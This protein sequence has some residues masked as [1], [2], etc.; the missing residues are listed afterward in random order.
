MFL[1]WFLSNIG[2]IGV[3]LV[4]EMVGLSESRKSEYK[5]K[6]LILLVWRVN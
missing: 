5:V 2:Y 3:G 1:K 6:I 4:N